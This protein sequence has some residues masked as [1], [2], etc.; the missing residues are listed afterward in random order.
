MQVRDLIERLKEYPEDMAVMVEVSRRSGT[1]LM[2]LVERANAEN[3]DPNVHR[4][5]GNQNSYSLSNRPCVKI[6]YIPEN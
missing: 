3:F 5:R 6:S 1:L 4:T 2:P